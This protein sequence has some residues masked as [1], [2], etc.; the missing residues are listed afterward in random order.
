MKE[1]ETGMSM[2]KYACMNLSEKYC[3]GEIDCV[4]CFP[5]WERV[6]E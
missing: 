5:P 3:S 6:E 1:I 4:T 2:S